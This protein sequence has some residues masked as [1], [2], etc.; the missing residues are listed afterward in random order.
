MKSTKKRGMKALALLMA[1]T[2]SIGALAG[3]GTKGNGGK[4]G[5]ISI[6][7]GNWPT[8]AGTEL[9]KFNERKATFE[10]EHPNVE[11][12]PSEWAFDLKSFYAK[13]EGGKLPTL[14]SAYFTEIDSIIGGGYAADI[15]EALEKRGYND[16]IN[17]QLFEL[18]SNEEGK[19]SAFP[20]SPYALGVAYN[21]DLFEKTG[22]MNEDGT[23]KQPKDWDELVEFAVKIKETTGKPGFLLPSTANAGGWMFSAIAWSYGTDFMKQ[24]ES[25]KWIATFDTPEAE[26]ALQWVK[27]LKWKY[28]VIPENTLIDNAEAYKQYGTENVGMI[29]SPGGAWEASTYEMPV[30]HFGLMAIPA[31]PKRHVTLLGGKAYFMAPDATPE[32]IDACLDWLEMTISYNVTEQIRKNKENSYITNR[33]NNQYIGVNGISIWNGNTEVSQLTKELVEK[34]KNA[35]LNHVKLYNDSLSNG[36]IEIQPEEPMFCQALY[37]ILDNCIQ[38]VWTDKNADCAKILKEQNA[39]FQRDYLDS[40]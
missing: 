14:Y 3:C 15:S 8:T 2:L 32:Q 4:D 34:Y 40:L 22:L 17:K 16:K 12:V 11:I 21:V 20:S 13:A 7:I 9:D 37:G 33:E 24:D 1:A 36:S 31:G 27:D 39:N 25:G 30:D 28:D 18:V 10:A 23:P 5:K 26:A 6:T 29:L 35:D 19:I 38:K